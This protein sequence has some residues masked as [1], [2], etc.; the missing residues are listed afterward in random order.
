MFISNC[1]RELVFDH[2]ACICSHELVPCSV[3][4]IQP[5]H[6]LLKLRGLKLGHTPGLKPILEVKV[7]R[8]LNVVGVEGHS[9]PVLQIA[10]EG[11]EPRP[12][13]KFDFNSHLECISLDV[14]TNLTTPS[15]K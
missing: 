15:V 13:V 2:S 6:V 5:L 8:P 7:E 10:I 9:Q 14:P 11:A 1:K 4:E 3:L 12:L